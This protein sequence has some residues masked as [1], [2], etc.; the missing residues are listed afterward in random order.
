MNTYMTLMTEFLKTAKPEEWVFVA[1]DTNYDEKELL[2]WMAKQP[3]CPE[4]AAKAIYWYLRPGFFTRYTY[5]NLPDWSKEDFE[6]IR[7]IEEKY[8]NGFYEKS[9]VGFDPSDDRTGGS[10][11]G[12]NLL[13]NYPM[14]GEGNQIPELMFRP[15]PGRMLTRH[16]IPAGWDN[17]MPPQIAKV[18]WN[19][20]AE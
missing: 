18:V 2:I 3:Q 7:K 19:E 15:T 20:G 8:I 10:V 6:L 5:A 9:Y 4:A 1:T 11:N 14:S 12:D 17:G 13:N 16:D